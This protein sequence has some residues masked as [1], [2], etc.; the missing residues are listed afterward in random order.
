[1]TAGAF[2]G[3][4]RANEPI[5]AAVPALPDEGTAIADRIESGVDGVQ[6]GNF[7]GKT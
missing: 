2:E 7:V 5:Q 4:R 6:G 3:S 1:L